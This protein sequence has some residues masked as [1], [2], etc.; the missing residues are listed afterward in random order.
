[1]FSSTRRNASTKSQS[2]EAFLER[3]RTWEVSIVSALHEQI[4]TLGRVLAV[5][6]TD[7]N[8]GTGAPAAAAAAAAASADDA[9]QPEDLRVLEELEE[10]GTEFLK[11][12]RGG[13]C[14]LVGRYFELDFGALWAA[15]IGEVIRQFRAVDARTVQQ[16]MSDYMRGEN[17]GEDFR[18][19]LRVGDGG[20]GHRGSIHD[21]L[22]EKNI[23]EGDTAVVS[24]CRQNRWP[25]VT[26]LVEQGAI[27]NV[28]AKGG[29]VTDSDS[30]SDES[31]NEEAEGSEK[32]F[33]AL[34]IACRAAKWELDPDYAGEFSLEYRPEE[35]DPTV[36]SELREALKALLSKTSEVQKCT[37]AEP[38]IRFFVWH[39]F[40][41]LIEL[42][43]SRGVDVDEMDHDGCTALHVMAAAGRPDTVRFLIE[44]GADVQKLDRDNNEN[45]LTLAC[46]KNDELEKRLEPGFVSRLRGVVEILLDRGVDVNARGGGGG[47]GESAL[48][49][50]VK[51]HHLEI[52]QLLRERGAA[53]EN[54]LELEDED[55]D[56]LLGCALAGRRFETARYL[57]AEGANVIHEDWN[58]LDGAFDAAEMELDTVTASGQLE[59]LE[60]DEA[61]MVSTYRPEGADPAR[62]SLIEGTLIEMIKKADSEA[63]DFKDFY[64]TLEISQRGA[65]D[66]LFHFAVWHGFIDLAKLLVE[67]G[68]DINKV[69]GHDWTALRLA[70]ACARPD[71]VQFGAVSR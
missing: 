24:A 19:C 70:A 71:F 40:E 23:C 65:E 69:N 43:L 25:I 59:G 32:R 55:G 20:G 2:V 37:K 5:K 66:T 26:Y 49:R 52:V 27:R 62:R 60:G 17:D 36:R 56:T 4:E 22:E 6:N 29:L 64:N 53:F 16:E 1:M 34:T 33:T 48:R 58:E 35:G 13:L 3:L 68:V 31:G 18:L 11:S 44:K 45:A 12:V 28:D 47:E 38:L 63:A 30:D 54:E 67:K 46:M 9:L 42:A 50:A 10:T 21:D 8:P 57:L 15:G 39:G 51:N 7:E 61:V 14:P 41:D